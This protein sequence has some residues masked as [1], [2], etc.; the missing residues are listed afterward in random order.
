VCE[1]TGM[2]REGLFRADVFQRGQWRDSYLYA[3]IDGEEAPT[4]E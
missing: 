4:P 3:R 2:R 1:K